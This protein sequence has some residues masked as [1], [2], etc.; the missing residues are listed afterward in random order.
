[1]TGSILGHNMGINC[2][3]VPVVMAAG[4]GSRMTELTAKRPKCLL[5]IGNLPMIYYPIALLERS[6]FHETLIVVQESSKTEISGALEKC[7]LK[8]KYDLVGIPGDEEWGTA[9]SLR[10]LHETGKIATDVLVIS[11]DLVTDLNLDHLIDLYRKKDASVCGLFAPA[12]ASPIITTPGPKSKNK[13]ERDLVGIDPDTS[14]LVLLASASDYETCLS[15]NGNLL[16]KYEKFSIYSKLL[17]AHV[18]IIRKWL[19]QYLGYNKDLSTLKGE[20]VP[21]VVKKQSKVN[22]PHTKVDDKASVIGA[23]IKTELSH[24]AQED[25]LTLKVRQMS[26]F[27]DN[28]CNPVYSGDTVRCYADILKDS[29]FTIRANT[30]QQYCVANRMVLQHWS[31]LTNGRELVNVSPLAVVSSTQLDSTSCIVA[32]NAKISEKTSLKNSFLG[33][34]VAVSPKSVVQDSVVMMNAK[35]GQGCK[36]YNCVICEDSTIEDNCE[37]KDCIVGS[38]HT[39]VASSKHSNEVLTVIDRLMEF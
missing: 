11:S 27:T 16:K 21:F 32:E 12:P 14:R 30:L 17:D 13:S 35:I 24:F 33:A 39:V 10:H 26:S 8:I 31:A 25:E 4:K 18:Y 5:P 1:M 36:I 2:E 3:L 22:K 29:E 28:R 38:Q 9:D 15:L 34:G 6:G 37:L 7:G 19:C 23:D 20:V